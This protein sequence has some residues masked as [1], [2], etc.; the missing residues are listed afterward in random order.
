MLKSTGYLLP[1]VSIQPG[2]RL[3]CHV[4]EDVIFAGRGQ[5]GVLYDRRTTVISKFNFINREVQ[6]EVA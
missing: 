4:H 5:L 2:R 6:S 1:Q 3:Y